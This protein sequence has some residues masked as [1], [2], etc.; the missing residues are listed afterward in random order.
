MQMSDAELG[1]SGLGR[2]MYFGERIFNDI[3]VTKRRT[4]CNWSPF[5][6]AQQLNR[7]LNQH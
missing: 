6:Q 1:R 7:F 5:L 4:I 2:A 3:R